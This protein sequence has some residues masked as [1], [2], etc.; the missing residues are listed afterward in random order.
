[1]N[2]GDVLFK[3]NEEKIRT[4]LG[5]DRIDVILDPVQPSPF[6]ASHKIEKLA[7]SVRWLLDEDLPESVVPYPTNGGFTFAVGDRRFVYDRLGLR[8]V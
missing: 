2:N 3:A 1:M 6:D 5:D 7:V 4:R 8:R